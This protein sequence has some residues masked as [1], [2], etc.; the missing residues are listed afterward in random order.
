[1]VSCAQGCAAVAGILLF[2]LLVFALVGMQLFAGTFGECA[3][4][5]YTTSET[6][7]AAGHIWYNPDFG[8]FDNVLSSMV[9]L[10]EMMTTEQWPL[11]LHMMEVSL[12]LSPSLTLISLR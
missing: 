3:L 12:T 9:L 4:N 1:V 2:F 5:N 8:S 7:A 11:A 6:C 10:F